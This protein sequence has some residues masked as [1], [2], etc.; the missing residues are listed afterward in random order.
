MAWGLRLGGESLIPQA[1]SG[2]VLPV[3][4][5]QPSPAAALE[6]AHPAPP[7][8]KLSFW[9]LRRSSEPRS[10]PSPSLDFRFGTLPKPGWGGV[11]R[12]SFPHRGGDSGAGNPGRGRCNLTIHPGPG[13]SFLQN[14]GGQ[15]VTQELWVPSSGSE[16][17]WGWRRGGPGP[18]ALAARSMRSR[19][20]GCF[21]KGRCLME[22]SSGNPASPRDPQ[23]RRA[24]DTW[25][26]SL[27][28]P[29]SLQ[30]LATSP[31]LAPF[32]PRAPNQEE[33]ARPAQ[34]GQPRA[35]FH[36]QISAGPGTE[37]GPLQTS[38]RPGSFPQPL[39]FPATSQTG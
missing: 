28:L 32:T 27:G 4:A 18:R 7:G 15:S 10:C 29:S 22:G 1:V 5:Q 17:G 3:G 25:G 31:G 12:G 34:S 9:P 8:L 23:R 16:V 38:P 21:A 20:L 36:P 33:A 30:G 19:T 37:F 6:G 35:P 26:L 14:G 2:K 11:K 24:Q 39:P 13:Q